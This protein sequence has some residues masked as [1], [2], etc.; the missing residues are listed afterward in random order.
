MASGDGIQ[1]VGLIVTN[2]SGTCSFK[3]TQEFAAEEL[4]RLMA[5]GKANQFTAWAQAASVKIK[6]SRSAPPTGP[7][8]NIN[9]NQWS[10]YAPGTSYF[11]PVNEVTFMYINGL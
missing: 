4:P 1:T 2:D 3:R 8:F 7:I 10:L 6:D 11:L 9:A 5:L